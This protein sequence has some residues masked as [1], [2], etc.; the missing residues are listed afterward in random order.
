MIHHLWFFFLLVFIWN[1]IYAQN[2][3]PDFTSVVE[4]NIPA[5]VIVNATKKIQPFD[6]RPS[7][8]WPA[9]GTAHAIT[10]T[11]TAVPGS[12]DLDTIYNFRSGC[13]AKRFRSN[14]RLTIAAI[15]SVT[16][17][18]CARTTN[19]P[20][21]PDIHVTKKTLITTAT[22]QACLPSRLKA[23]QKRSNV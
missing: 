23:A 5:V 4:K 21:A 11:I 14:R 13:T 3:L 9:P 18:A 16:S 10:Q 7:H 20:T 12:K 8:K 6:S 1:N 22:T 15:T 2:N 19:I 17:F